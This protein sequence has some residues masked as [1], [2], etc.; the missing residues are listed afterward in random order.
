MTE[1]TYLW[2][3]MLLAVLSPGIVE[4]VCWCLDRIWP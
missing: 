1:R 2:G 3:A 4:G